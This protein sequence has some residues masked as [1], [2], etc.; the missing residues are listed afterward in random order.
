MLFL[1]IFYFIKELNIILFCNAK[2][3]FSR[4][5]FLSRKGVSPKPY[6]HAAPGQK[7]RHIRPVR[8]LHRIIPATNSGAVL[9]VFIFSLSAAEGVCVREKTTDSCQ[10]QHTETVSLY[11][12]SFSLMDSVGSVLN[13]FYKKP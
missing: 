7:T 10:D 9:A 11:I 8:R 12:W 2:L 6:P 5:W 13:F 3:F 1:I 4:L